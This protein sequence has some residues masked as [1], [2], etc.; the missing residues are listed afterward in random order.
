MYARAKNTRFVGTDEAYSGKNKLSSD[1]VIWV[2]QYQRPDGSWVMG[3]YRTVAGEDIKEVDP[4]GTSGWNNRSVMN[5]E[6]NRP[7]SYEAAFPI[8]TSRNKFDEEGRREAA[9]ALEKYGVKVDWRRHGLIDLLN[10]QVRAQKADDLSA[11]G[12]DV[13][14]RE[15]SYTD[16]EDMLCIA[17][18]LKALEA[19]GITKV[20]DDSNCQSLQRMLSAPAGSE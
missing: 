19:R 2:E 18:N 11:M 12:V 17:R 14:W 16:L 8:L 15:M 7:V 4:S 9:A 10:Y 5:A 13:D 1:R 6:T 3:H 20:P